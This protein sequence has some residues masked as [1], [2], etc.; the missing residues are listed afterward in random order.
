[1]EC[2]LP[3]SHAN[4]SLQWEEGYGLLY[5]L[6]ASFARLECRIF[7]SVRHFQI[8]P[9]IISL[10]E[11]IDPPPLYCVTDNGK[12]CAVSFEGMTRVHEQ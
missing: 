7:L 9:A 2:V 4:I 3:Q 1:M 5:L 6:Y 10:S 8:P 12:L 11:N